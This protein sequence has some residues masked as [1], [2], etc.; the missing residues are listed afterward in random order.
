MKRKILIAEDDFD[1]VQLLKLYLESGGYEVITAENGID[2]LQLMNE[3]QI[4]LAVIDIMMPRMDGYSL[5]QEIRAKDNIP[6]IILSAKDAESDKVVG[7]NLGAD[8]YVTKPFSP[9]EILAR[10]QSNLRRYYQLGAQ[11]GEINEIR[12][13][14]LVLDLHQMSL[15]KKDEYISLTPMEFK[16][17]AKLMSTPGRVF[18]KSQL[19]ESASGYCFESDENTIMVHISKLREKIEDDPKSPVYIKTVRGLGYKIEKL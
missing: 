13:G 11:A 16:I 1:I 19:Y 6:I 3:H 2:A 7:L 9:L 4:D 5:I 14:E 8:D 17:L 18:T 15:T 10:I 12:L